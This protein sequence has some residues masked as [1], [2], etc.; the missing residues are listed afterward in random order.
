MNLVMEMKILMLMEDYKFSYILETNFTW[1]Q[2]VL[3]KKT[4]EIEEQGEMKY[5]RHTLLVILMYESAIDPVCSTDC[6]WLVDWSQYLMVIDQSV[7]EQGAWNNIV[8]W[9]FLWYF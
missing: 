4:L 3:Q 8:S 2:L 6:I 5:F 9:H 7:F 1:Q